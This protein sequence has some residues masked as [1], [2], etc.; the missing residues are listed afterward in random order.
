MLFVIVTP[1]LIVTRAVESGFPFV[2]RA[3]NREF[4]MDV[5][6]YEC[7]IAFIATIECN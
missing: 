1:L 3:G 4:E 6:S 2:V 5:R 7:I